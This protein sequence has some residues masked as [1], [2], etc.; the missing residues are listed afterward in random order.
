MLVDYR[1]RLVATHEVHNGGRESSTICSKHVDVIDVSADGDDENVEDPCVVRQ[2]LP[3][4]P[5]IP[6]SCR[7]GMC[8]ERMSEYVACRQGD[9]DRAAQFAA[10]PSRGRFLHIRSVFARKNMHYFEFGLLKRF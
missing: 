9:E 8:A 7:H 10:L 5:V 2:Y 1:L 4:A 6:R 3:V